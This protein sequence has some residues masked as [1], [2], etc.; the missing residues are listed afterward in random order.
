MAMK[1]VIPTDET[2]AQKILD[3]GCSLK[4]G[5]NDNA[6]MWLLRAAP[7]WPPKMVEPL[8]DHWSTVEFRAD[9]Q[10][11]GAVELARKQKYYKWSPL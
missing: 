7:G 4:L 10:I 6:V 8:L 11:H 9:Q 1:R 2:Q 3:Y 5:E